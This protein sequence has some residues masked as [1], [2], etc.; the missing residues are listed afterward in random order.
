MDRHGSQELLPLQPGREG[1]DPFPDDEV[2]A[3]DAPGA[4]DLS[5]EEL[6]ALLE[7]DPE[8]CWR[9]LQGLES[10]EVESR[11]R[12]IEELGRF[13]ERQGL[14]SL[15]RLLTSSRDPET[16]EAALAA[17]HGPHGPVQI[18]R[19]TPLSRTI[20]HRDKSQLSSGV[21]ETSDRA[22]T[23]R[24]LVLAGPRSQPRI[25]RCLVTAVDGEGRGSIM[26]SASQEFQR[27]TAVF[28]CDVQRGIIDV[29]GMVESESNLA[30]R[31]VDELRSQAQVDCVEGV[32]EL[33][34]RLLAGSLMLC[35]PSVP[36]AV[37]HWLE[38]TLGH[39]FQPQPLPTRITGGG[40][41][42]VSGPSLFRRALEVLDTCPTWLDVSP[43]TFELAEEISLREGKAATD[44]QRDAGAY[45][46][47]FEHRLI[48][49]LELY[50]RML[51][52]MAWFWQYSGQAELAQTAELL[53]WQLSDEQ[54]AVPAHPFAVA[55]MTRSLEAAQSRLGTAADP[56]S[57]RPK[58]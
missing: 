54:F 2:P 5:L 25:V 22:E 6:A 21:E 11:L 3:E 32:P 29:L 33:A 7:Q 4:E 18:R 39:R 41:A 17:L 47:L 24:S 38:G 37:R 56:R 42:E 58:S 48:Y 8:E 27:R 49:R 55:L 43:L 53:A 52:W 36:P 34:L 31:L 40:W 45:R 44:P 13:T 35:G 19:E 20:E 14:A 9:A 10:V 23:S 51:L 26:I 1:L 46:Y 28:L 50:R 15:L 16:R 12:I 57:S 30:G